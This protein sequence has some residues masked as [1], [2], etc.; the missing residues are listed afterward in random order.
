MR[1]TAYLFCVLSF[2]CNVNNLNAQEITGR[3][4]TYSFNIGQKEVV[5]PVLIIENSSILFKDENSS[6]SLE[7][8]EKANLTFEIKNT[9]KG[10]AMDLKMNIAEKNN[11][12]GIFFGKTNNIGRIGTNSNKIV[13]IPITSNQFLQEGQASILISFAERNGFEPRPIEVMVKT[14]KFNQPKLKVVDYV[15]SS[16]EKEITKGTPFRISIML[17]NIGSGKASDISISMKSPDNIYLVAGNQNDKVKDLASGDT[18]KVTYSLIANSQFSKATAQFEFNVQ[19]KYLAFGEIKKIDIPVSQ[20]ADYKNLAIAP[21]QTTRDINSNTP[22]NI[23][24]FGADIEKNIPN[25]SKKNAANTYV[26]I[27]GNEDYTTFQPDLKTES[28]VDYAI[29]DA[30]TFYEYCKNTFGI[31]VNNITMLTNALSNPMKREINRLRDKT[32]YGGENLEIIFYYSG[33]GFPD[34]EKNSYIMPVDISGSNVKDGIKLTEL[35]KELTTYPCKKVTVFIDAC[36]SGGGRNAGLVA[37]KAVKIQPKEINVEGN[38]V[39]FTASSGDEISTFYRDKNHGMFT[40]FLLKKLQDTKGM[41]SYGEMSDY[42]KKVV[43]FTSGDKN[44]KAQNPQTLISPE[45]IEKWYD[46]TFN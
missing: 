16:G 5:P 36:F 1:K 44:Y 6:N 10:D 34:D 27:F 42:L 38:I 23:V 41:V 13:E 12:A 2:L 39:V 24:Q 25:G 14:S 18:T 7:A 21:T 4:S 15:L 43:P 20:S 22:V 29:N 8:F 31:P 19:E 30:K 28:N 33:H 32:M 9:G 37:A 40:Y 11:S 45:I 3:S 35:Y 26:L 46:W 17:Q